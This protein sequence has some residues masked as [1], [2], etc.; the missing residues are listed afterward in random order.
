MTPITKTIATNFTLQDTNGEKVELKELTKD[1]K[2][3]LLFFPLAFSNTCTDEL[4]QIRDNMKMYNSLDAN[5]V[6][7]SVDSFFTLKEFK[8]A[9]NLNFTLLSDFNKVVSQSYDCLYEDF[10]GMK[11][12]SKRGAFVI[13]RDMEIE[14]AEVLDDASDLPDFKSISQ[15]L[16]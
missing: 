3:L 4:C 11:G 12:V 5:V 8:K 14:Y 15:V 2:V 6:G 10:Y 1:G 7:I 13:N 16:K 9:N